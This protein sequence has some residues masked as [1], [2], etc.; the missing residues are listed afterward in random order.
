MWR[1]WRVS[2]VVVVDVFVAASR[3]SV[4]LFID[5][6]D[7]NI[8]ES[9]APWVVND[10]LYWM[11]MQ[12]AYTNTFTMFT[13]LFKII[14]ILVTRSTD[15]ARADVMKSFTTLLSQKKK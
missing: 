9:T 2:V 6:Y 7:T 15:I 14:V 10:A 8:N 4:S 12:Y 5:K 11:F 3:C 1:E 13:I